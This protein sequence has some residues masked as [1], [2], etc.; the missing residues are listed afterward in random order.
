[1]YSEMPR[2]SE[3]SKPNVHRITQTKYKTKLWDLQREQTASQLALE[4]LVRPKSFLLS[5]GNSTKHKLKTMR[6]TQKRSKRR[7][8]RWKC[9]RNSSETG[10]SLSCRLFL[11][12]NKRRRQTKRPLSKQNKNRR[13]RSNR[14]SLVMVLISRLKY[15]NLLRMSKQMVSRWMCS[16][17]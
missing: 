16:N 9:S 6:R 12:T 4:M 17:S 5:A 7:R 14:W 2:H 13:T 10:I 15:L 8:G 3:K 11:R 1:M